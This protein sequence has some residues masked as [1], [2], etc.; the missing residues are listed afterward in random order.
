MS[1]ELFALPALPHILHSDDQDT[2]N[3]E[4][5]SFQLDILNLYSE[6]VTVA[7]LRE[8]KRDNMTF[9]IL[10]YN[11]RSLSSNFDSFNLFLNSQKQKLDVVLVTESWLDESSSEFVKIAGYDEFHTFRNNKKGG[12]VSFFV[13]SN[14][15]SVALPKDSYVN[16]HIE[17]NSIK[18]IANH[19]DI[20]FIGIYRP[21]GGDIEKFLESLESILKK[22]AGKKIFILGDVNLDLLKIHSDNN[23][24]CLFNL[25]VSFGLFPTTTRATRY[26][27]KNP[28]HSSLLDQTWTNIEGFQHSYIVLSDDSDHF[29]CINF[30]KNLDSP[31]IVKFVQKTFRKKATVSNSAN[32]LSKLLSSNFDFIDNHD[33]PL[34]DRFEKFDSLFFNTYDENFPVKSSKVSIKR[35]SNPWMT[36]ELRTEIDKKHK[37]YKLKL[38]GTVPDITYKNFKKSLDA[39]I[40]AAKKEYFKSNLDNLSGDAKGHWKFLNRVMNR[41]SSSQESPS[42]IELNGETF[43]DVESISS[44]FREHFSTVGE[45]IHAEI[46]SSSRP[47]PDFKKYLN[48]IQHNCKFEFKPATCDDIISIINA[49]K[50]KN[51]RID[52]V[53]NFLYK[54]SAEIIAPHLCKLINLSLS[55]GL[56]PKIFK[57]S[58]VIPLFK[59]GC[60]KFM[61]N[62][63]PIAILPTT[64]KIYEKI[65]NKQIVSYFDSNS[66]LSDF[67][68]GF[69]KK[70]STQDTNTVL[71]D[72]IY[73]KLNIKSN[74]IA[75]YIDLKKAFDS[76]NLDILLEKLKYYGFGTIPLKWFSSYLMNRTLSVVIKNHVSAPAPLR[77]SVPQG[78]ILGPTLFNIFINDFRFSTTATCLQYADDTTILNEDPDFRKLEI[79]TN[80]SLVSI[81][82]YLLANDLALNSSKT[83]Y[84]IFSNKH[85]PELNININGSALK[86]V[87]SYKSLGLIIDDRLNFNEHCVKVSNNLSKL[88]Y[89]LYK[90]KSFLD[91]KT[92]LQL[93]HALGYPHIT[94]NNVL[95]G[96]APS[97]YLNRIQV[98]QN[99]IMRNITSNP[100]ATASFNILQILNFSE[101]HEHQCLIYMFKIENSLCSRIVS[102]T[103]HSNQFSHPYE[104]R[105]NNIRTPFCNLSISQNSF[106]VHGPKFWNALPNNLKNVT[107][108]VQ[109]FSKNSKKLILSKRSQS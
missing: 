78:S 71:L 108:T 9:S 73:N 6:Y 27:D 83:V 89:I 75:T 62:Y 2:T 86:Q 58:K 56:F 18:I 63:R 38:S 84:M 42:N 60:K 15:T 29:P 33:L 16:S 105:N 98:A 64:S 57:N 45:K 97:K 109:T 103:I 94:Y 65:V 99:R 44:N 20:F 32:F 24:F 1:A 11:I 67:Q 13:N 59:G 46:E 23:A 87:T 37:L 35:L 107:S 77:F 102:E 41:K 40:Y 39:K 30:F 26:N 21:P 81:S 72:Y 93:Y 8:A 53:P 52:S 25:L 54:L 51:C 17:V 82:E 85:R 49:M 101:I 43:E 76:V 104:T 68:F 19:T 36:K 90:N 96:V 95:Y 55:V 4:V 7:E 92:K 91:L 14:K 66:L 106:S 80:A 22:M 79:K 47:R 100:S 88:N 74:I 3:S 28:S 48:N 31:K 12:G 10:N 34:E 61:G 70:H 50:N 5:P 69:R